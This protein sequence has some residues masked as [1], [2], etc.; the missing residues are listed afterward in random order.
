MPMELR[1][2]IAADVRLLASDPTIK[3]RLSDLGMV[4]RGSTPT[5]YAAML[6]EQSAKWAAFARMY[7]MHPQP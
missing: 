1:E 5:E 6:A 7:G 4:A 2:R 3:Q